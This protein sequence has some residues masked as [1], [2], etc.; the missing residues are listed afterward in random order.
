MSYPSAPW[1]L[2]GFAVQTLQFVDTAQARAFV[3]P[4]LDIVPVLPGKTL[5]V[6]YLAS[7]APESVLSY[8]ELIV[9]P[10]L[11]RYRKNVGFWI[12][13]IYVDHP[14]S[15]AGGREIWGLPKELAQFTWQMGEESHVSVRQG[16]QVLCNLHYAHHRR[17]WRQPLFLPAL[18]M[19][20]KDLLRFKGTFTARLGF[21]K[22]SL[23]IPFESPFAALGLAGA[24]RICHYD[25][26]TFV[27]H[28]PRV[29][30]HATVLPQA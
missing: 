23:D 7:Y 12:S 28:A 1:T 22:G 21:G 24:V 11:T 26:M 9:V 3:P 17:L 5:G 19:R 2:K 15:M 8:N 25:D 30:G 10:A 6:V 14:D 27:A 18:S 13:H 4:D 20:G 29:I 16:E